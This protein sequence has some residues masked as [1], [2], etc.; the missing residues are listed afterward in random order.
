MLSR[1][2]GWVADFIGIPFAD[3]G[4]DE[5]GCDCWG[6]VR[7]VY[8]QR[9]RIVLPDHTDLYDATEQVERIEGAIAAHRASWRRVS[10]PFFLDGDV[11]LL[12]VS[13]RVA[14][15]GMI[16]G[17]PWFLHSSEGAASACDRLDGLRW[18]RRLDSV[19]R[20]PAMLAAEPGR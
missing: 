1:P 20:H 13:G 17:F 15:V 8:R 7:L 18:A 10:G 4:R 14:H 5:A 3:R 6:L 16:I 11:A 9:F 19:W 2:P 12:R